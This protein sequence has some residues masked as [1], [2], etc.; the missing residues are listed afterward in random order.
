MRKII[1]KTVS[2]WR[3]NGL[4]AGERMAFAHHGSVGTIAAVY[5]ARTFYLRTKS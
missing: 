5:D 4:A 1:Y 3:T 2:V